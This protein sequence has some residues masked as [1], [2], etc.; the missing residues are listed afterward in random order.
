M[1]LRAI[2]AVFMR[3]GT[4][5]A[6]IFRA[7][8][9]PADRADWAPIFLA[10]MGSPDPAMRQLD[11]MG[12]G[13][14][15]LSKCCVVGPPSRPD[16]DVDY[17][18]AQVAIDRPEVDYASN[19]GNMSSAI[20]PFA[21]DEG[22]VAPPAGNEAVVR[23]H[24][25]NTGKIIVARFPM[26]A[27]RAAVTGDLAIDGVAG[28]GAPIRLDFTD[29]GGAGTGRLLPTGNL[30]DRLD[31]PGLGP[32]RVTLIDAA[33]PCVLVAAADLG[34]TATETPAAME[35][36]TALIAG[37]EALRRA[38]SVRMG[39][40]ADLEAAA[41][42]I[43]VPKVGILAPP[44]DA[45]VLSGA[46]QT[47]ASVDILARMMSSG[48]PHRAVPLTGALCLAVACRLPGT[49]AHDLVRPGEATD[50]V[51]V[52]HPS[53]AILVA[54]GVSS[55]PD[56]PRVSHATVFR[57]ARRLFQGEVLHVGPRV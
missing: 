1:A 38:A 36:D 27:G 20:G 28:T 33:N 7:G 42:I 3:G 54:A 4:S 21:V 34:M 39:L 19:C 43:S 56:G 23:I 10:A 24:N 37:I 50:P 49:V 2:R 5:K 41:R 25:T 53:G 52:G 26:E 13:V 44:A 29:P 32:Q 57:T 31:V 46:V 12:G 11:G 55:G 35:R 14:S 17:T 9:L 18:F 45:P 48:Q 47:A 40:A 8:D 30:T 6:L 51:R 16:A 15:S 22:L